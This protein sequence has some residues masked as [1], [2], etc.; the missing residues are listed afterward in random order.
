MAATVLLNGTK[1]EV[2][3]IRTGVKQGCVIV[4]TLFTIYLCAILFLLR[5]RLPHGVELDYR[6]DGRLFNLSRLKAKTKVTKT[7]VIDLQYADDC[8][9]LAHSAKTFQTSL[10]LFKEAYQ[11][12]DINIRKTEVINLLHAS[13][14]D[15]PKLNFSGEIQEDV[16]YFPCLRSNLSQKATIEAEIKH[17]I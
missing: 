4:P 1:S 5:D 2:F 15:L 13:M 14:Q 16:E 9:I 12:L 17:R 7:A 3:T 11:S 6:F 10:D 8:A